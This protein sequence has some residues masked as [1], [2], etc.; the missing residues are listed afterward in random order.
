MKKTITQRNKDLDLRRFGKNE[1]TKAIENGGNG[2]ESTG[3]AWYEKLLLPGQ[4]K[5]VAWA[6]KVDSADTAQLITPENAHLVSPENYGLTW[7]AP[8]YE[9]APASKESEATP[10]AFGSWDK[11]GYDT[12]NTTY[13]PYAMTTGFV[14]VGISVKY[15]YS[16]HAVAI[17]NLLS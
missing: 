2:G 4:P 14:N 10:I 6:F 17:N 12:F 5:P 13:R 1:Y 7:V 3:G 11:N 16:S 8:I 9:A 15:A